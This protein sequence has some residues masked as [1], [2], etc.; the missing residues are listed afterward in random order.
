[1][2]KVASIYLLLYRKRKLARTAAGKTR[3]TPSIAIG[4]AP[5]LCGN[6]SIAIRKIK[7]KPSIV[8][9]VARS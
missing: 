4:A 3:P 5:N 1:M 2:T 9:N 8:Q 7:A 6:A